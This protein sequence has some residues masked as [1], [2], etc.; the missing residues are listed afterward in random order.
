MSD[1]R[2]IFLQP[3]C[4]ADSHCEGRMWCED[5]APIDCEDGNP[6]TRYVLASEYERLQRELAEARER[7]RSALDAINDDDIAGAHL[8]LYEGVRTIDAAKEGER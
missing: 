2:E 8:I 4:C 3:E 1:P 5:D 6:W 7:I